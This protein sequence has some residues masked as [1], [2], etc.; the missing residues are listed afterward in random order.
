MIKFRYAIHKETGAVLRYEDWLKA[1]NLKG[2][3]G[4]TIKFS[5]N[6]MIKPK[7]FNDLD[8]LPLYETIS[9]TPEEVLFSNNFEIIYENELSLEELNLLFHK[10]K[11]Y[12]KLNKKILQMIERENK[13][14]C[15]YDTYKI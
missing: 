1:Y 2:Q 14:M 5:L 6:Y 3:N 8:K 4:N 9:F 7:T 12:I 10:S 13:I 11:D 15:K